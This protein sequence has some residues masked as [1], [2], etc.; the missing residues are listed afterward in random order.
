MTKESHGGVSLDA[1]CN[2]D[3]KVVLYHIDGES[4]I[5]DLLTKEHPIGA[6]DVSQGS[7]WQSGPEWLSKPVSQMPIKKYDQIYLKQDEEQ[8]CAH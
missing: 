2:V 5:A 8:W 4:N 6:Q 3:S 1:F 7:L